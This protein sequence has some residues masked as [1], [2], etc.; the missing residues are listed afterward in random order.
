MLWS[1]TGRNPVSDGRSV[2]NRMSACGIGESPV[3]K[4][5]AAL[6]MTLRVSEWSRQNEIQSH[7]IP[8]LEGIVY[9]G[10]GGGSSY[11]ARRPITGSVDVLFDEL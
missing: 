7:D 8:G 4:S 11:H 5:H 9:R 3:S 6:P 1:M 2:L 10:S